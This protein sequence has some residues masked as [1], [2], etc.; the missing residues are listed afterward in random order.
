MQFDPTYNY[1]NTDLT[2][3][4]WKIVRQKALDILRS[5]GM[6]DIKLEFYREEKYEMTDTGKRI[7]VQS[8]KTRLVR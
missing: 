3:P 7:T 6:Q 4:E 5:L 8:T 2:S 1:G